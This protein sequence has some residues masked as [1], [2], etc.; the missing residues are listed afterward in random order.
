MRE[1]PRPARRGA[2]VKAANLPR[3]GPSIRL[4][5]A[6]AMVQ[7][8]AVPFICL[9]C[10]ALYKV[11]RVQRPSS[12]S[13]KPVFCKTCR[14][15]FDSTD[16]HDILKYFLVDKPARP[17]AKRPSKKPQPEASSMAARPSPATIASDLRIQERMMLFCL[18]SGTD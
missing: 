13:S 14:R 9:Q 7:P 17:A 4:P 3:P 12:A 18:A 8:R 2:P 10:Q 5:F 11:F 15:P 16:G 1:V 6:C